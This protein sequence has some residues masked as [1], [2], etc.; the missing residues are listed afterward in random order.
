M[1]PEAPEASKTAGAVAD[2]TAR[3]RVARRHG[4]A[5]LKVNT[6]PH[7]D[8]LGRECA[9][10]QVPARKLPRPGGPRGLRLCREVI[11][12]AVG[13]AILPPAQPLIASTIAA[14]MRWRY[15]ILTTQIC[16]HSVLG[17]GRQEL[18]EVVGAPGMMRE[19]VEDRMQALPKQHAEVI[20][21][22]GKT[23]VSVSD[24]PTSASDGTVR[25][26]IEKGRTLTR[27]VSE[28]SDPTRCSRD[29]LGALD[30]A[31][32]EHERELIPDEEYAASQRAAAATTSGLT[33]PTAAM[34]GGEVGH[35]R[36]GGA[37]RLARTRRRAPGSTT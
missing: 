9:T 12:M 5:R 18:A 27:R 29:L 10:L 4:G 7:Q 8:Q 20:Q 31:P 21:G 19:T 11:A 14:A 13:R 2:E 15:H 34:F 33:T 17:Y 32:M 16:I 37:H 23:A 28:G 36:V 6:H 1:P 22:N 3:E 30:E 26:N 24:A 35:E 25:K